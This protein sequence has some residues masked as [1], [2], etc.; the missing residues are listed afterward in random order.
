[1]ASKAFIL[2]SIAAV[3]AVAFFVAAASDIVFPIPELGNCRDRSAC[4]EYC[5]DFANK[6]ACLAFAEAHGLVDKAALRDAKKL[7]PVGPSGCSG[8]KACSAYCGDA[9]H[10]EECLLFAREHGLVNQDQELLLKGPGPGG[11]VGPNQCRDY[12]AL[13]DNAEECLQFVEAHK[14]SSRMP[15]V[16][17]R[18]AILEK[19]KTEGGPGGCSSV[20]ECRA[21]CQDPA[22]IDACLEFA[23]EH[24]LTSPEKVR[25]LENAGIAS[26]PGGCRGRE[27]C[28][29]YCADSAHQEEC[30]A[31]A[32][33]NKF[34]SPDDAERARKLTGKPGPGGCRGES[35]QAYC[36]SPEHAD[37]CIA[38]AEKNGFLTKGELER[39]KKF[40]EVVRTGG[41]GGCTGPD[42]CRIYCTDPSH[43]KECIA[44]GKREGL[45]RPEDEAEFESAGRIEK[46]LQESGGPGGCKTREEC[47]AYCASANRVEECVA[48][49]A[50]HGGLTEERAREML[51]KFTEQ[52]FGTDSESISSDEMER[53]KTE[54]ERRFEEFKKLER[55][56]RGQGFSGSASST[57]GGNGSGG[58]AEG[59]GQF[60][61]PRNF[62]GPGGCTSPAECIRYCKEHPGDCNAPN[63]NSGG[64]APIRPPPNPSLYNAA[65]DFG[66]C[67][68]RLMQQTNT[69][70]TGGNQTTAP[71]RE[72]VVAECQRRFGN[73]SVNGA[74]QPLNGPLPGFGSPGNQ[75]IPLPL[76]VAPG[77]P[78][79]FQSPGSRG[80][81]LPQVSPQPSLTPMTSPPPPDEPTSFSGIGSLFASVF[82]GWLHLVGQ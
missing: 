64:V 71:A 47:Q 67:V 51:R 74:S 17:A 82:A 73:P 31:F 60:L 10:E 37:E 24:G 52:K 63:M 48:F 44:F 65:N 28:E 80:G 5:D 57:S 19:L 30:I 72:A 27:A 20:A 29:I 42:S 15:D 55:R 16:D 53:L 58:G 9:A 35:C 59:G 36:S 7:P 56:F 45:I 32:E 49:A 25:E 77:E 61:M 50:A 34:I 3:F 76:P 6:D 33:K 21:Y 12:C 69:G 70:L 2:S 18:A 78:T 66:R 79:P 4:A 22:N 8:R 68:A 39:A 40:A 11:C 75:N 1:M 38:F 26:G 54:A 43:R 13:P 41:P 62:V 46:K 14:L 81:F 23:Q